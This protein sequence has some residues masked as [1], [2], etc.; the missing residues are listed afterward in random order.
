MINEIMYRIFTTLTP[1]ATKD[2]YYTCLHNSLILSSDT[3]HAI[4]PNYPEKHQPSHIVN[5]NA[6]IC[7]K[8]SA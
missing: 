8:I 2:D 5:I 4:H 1:K 3:G 7:F 6:G